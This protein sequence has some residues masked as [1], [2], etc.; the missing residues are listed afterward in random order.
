MKL[1]VEPISGNEVQRIVV[2]LAATPADVVKRVS[3]AI[4]V[5]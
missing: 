5:K 4:A 1:D 2:K 3:E